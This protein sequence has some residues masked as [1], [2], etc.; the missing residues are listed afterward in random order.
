MFKQLIPLP[1]IALLTFSLVTAVI[2]QSRTRTVD[3]RVLNNAGLQGHE[4]LTYGLTLGETRFSPL[5]QLNT[6][7][8]QQ[9]GPVWSYDIGPGGGPQGTPLFWGDT[10]SMALRPGV[11]CLLWMRGPVKN[12]GD[13]IPR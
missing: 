11:S 12:D 8:I 9:L 3:D 13:G 1:T 7:N 5:T 6:T 10:H 4:W 2:T